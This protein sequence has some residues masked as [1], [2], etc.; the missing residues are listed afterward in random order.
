VTTQAAGDGPPPFGDKPRPNIP[1]VLVVEDHQSNREMVA[2]QLQHLGCTVE[3]ADDGMQA[4]VAVL[5]DRFDLVLMDC[6]MPRV[7]GFQAARSIREHER[8]RG[9]PRVPIVAVSACLLPDDRAR[10]TSAGMDD[11]LSKPATLSQLREVLERW[12]GLTRSPESPA[13]DPQAAKP[14]Q[15]PSSA[16]HV[17]DMSALSG[18]RALRQPG[19]PNL[20]INLITD[21]L[22]SS[23]ARID[24][25]VNEMRGG[26]S[27]P[28]DIAHGLKSISAMLGAIELAHTLG[29]IETAQRAGARAQISAELEPLRDQY[30]RAC[31][32]LERIL[33]AERQIEEGSA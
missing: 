10:C 11:F 14:S 27:S 32:A 21:Y 2:R 20:V 30:A 25:L 23:P 4:C 24:E 28:G 12:T 1:N 22:Q 5:R 9:L 6:Q 18:L 13:Q 29:R 7:D 15:A 31:A 16:Q 33:R 26:P 17:L 3:L 8:S 19:R